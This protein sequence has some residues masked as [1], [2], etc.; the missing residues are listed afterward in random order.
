MSTFII[1]GIENITENIILLQYKISHILGAVWYLM[2]TSQE[3]IVELEKVQR[4]AGQVI[5]DVK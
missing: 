5:K 1:K 3:I 4:K 2:L